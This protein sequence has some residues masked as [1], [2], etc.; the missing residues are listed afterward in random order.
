MRAALR[1]MAAWLAGS[2][3]AVAMLFFAYAA[4]AANGAYVVD[5]AD[6]AGPGQC[7]VES[8]AALASNTDFIAAT[9]PSCGIPFVKPT[10]IG[11]LFARTRM[12]G[13]W[14]TSFGI[15]GKM[16]LAPADVGKLGIGASVGAVF[17]VLT[18]ETQAVFATVP[19]TF[20]VTEEFRF[21]LNGGWLW[22]PVNDIHFATYGAAFEWEF[23]KPFTLI[24]EVFGLIGA[25]PLQT[26]I[27]PRVQAGLRYTPIEALDFDVIYGRNVGG[28]NANWVTVG[29]NVRFPTIGK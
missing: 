14:G 15:K 8:W 18:G 5:D 27:Q 13:E 26:V 16:N 24:G 2:A 7:K 28:E 20:K 19:F 29:M 6:A 25:A 11:F 9:A 10:E 21:H 23:V 17:D 3:A 12:D 1:G 22:N 4:H